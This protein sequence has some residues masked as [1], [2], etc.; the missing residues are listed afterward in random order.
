MMENQSSQKVIVTDSF[1]PPTRHL[2]FIASFFW[3][4]NSQRRGAGC[5][6]GNNL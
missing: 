4:A 5:E 3:Q 2:D 1:P 6:S